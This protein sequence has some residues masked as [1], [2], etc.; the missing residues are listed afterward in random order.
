MIVFTLLHPQVVQGITMTAQ[1]T[2]EM[3]LMAVQTMPLALVK[4]SA[5]VTIPPLVGVALTMVV[6]VGMA[7]AAGT[8]EGGETSG[9]GFSLVDTRE[10]AVCLPFSF[11]RFFNVLLGF[12]V[13]VYHLVSHG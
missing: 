13:A 12:L 11:G 8:R 3:A 4:I 6:V 7:A 10:I 1:T 9:R 5:L 2:V